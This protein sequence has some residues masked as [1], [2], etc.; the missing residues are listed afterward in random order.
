MG[1]ER[2]ADLPDARLSACRPGLRGI[3]PVAGG[4]ILGQF[5]AGPALAEQDWSPER[6]FAQFRVLFVALRCVETLG[7]GTRTNRGISAAQHGSITARCCTM[8]LREPPP[9]VAGP[10]GRIR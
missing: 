4:S 1:A 2:N 10:V 7:R 6:S 8:N 9:E 3:G 5:E